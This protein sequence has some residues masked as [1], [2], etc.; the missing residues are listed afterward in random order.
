MGIRRWRSFIFTWTLLAVLV[1]PAAAQNVRGSIGGRVRDESGAVVPKATV[2]LMHQ[3]SSKT[4][5]TEAGPE[6]EFLFSNLPAGEYALEI[7]VTGF[8]KSKTSLTLLIGQKVEKDVTLKVGQATSVDYVE[9]YTEVVHHD[10]PSVGA[11]ISNRQITGLPL[12]GRNFATLSLLVPGVLPSAEGSALSVRGGFSFSVNGGREDSNVFQLDGVYNGDPTLNGA[13]VI[14]PVDAIR[15]FAVLTNSYDASFG[16]NSGGQINVALHRGGNAFHGTAYEFFRNAALDARN[17]FAPASEPDPKY[18]RNQFG[19]SAGGPIVRERTFFFA[20][21]EGRIA[22]E[23]IT[24]ISNVPTAAERSGDFTASF[25]PTPVVP[26]FGPLPIIPAFFQHPVG[27]AIAQLFPLPNRASPGAN[28]VSSPTQRDNEHHFD[29]RV[30]QVFKQA[31]LA[32]R[33]SF[34]DRDFFEPF[35]TAQGSSLVPGYGNHVTPRFHNLMVSETHT[36]SPNFVNEFRFGFNRVDSAVTHQNAGTSGNAA[37]GL[38]D[39]ASSRDLGLSQINITGFAT[40]GHEINSPNA[41]ANNTWQF[42]DQANWVRGKHA[43][44]F[45]FDF[46]KVSQNAFRDVQSR[47]FLSFLGVITGNPLA[48][49]LLGLPTVTGRALVD[50]PQRLRAESYQWFVSDA[51]RIHPSLLL[52]AGLRYEFVSPPVDPADRAQVYNP[53]TG[54]I[55]QVGTGGVP[56][57]G[58]A[59]DKNNFAPRLGLAWTL[60][61]SHGNTVLRAGYGMYY[62]QSP[63]APGEGL[64]FSPPFFTFNLAFQ[65][66]M[67]PPLTLSNPFPGAAFPIPTPPSALTYQRDLR[68]PYVQHWSLGVQQ[69]L[70]QGRVLEAVY[71]ASKGTKLL[72]GRDINQPA[73]S[74]V[75]PNLRPNP[76]FDDITAVESRASSTFGSLQLR[77]QQELRHG[78]TVLAGYTLSESDDDASSFFA[79]TGDPN[80]PQDSNNV[81]A[82]RARSN[83]DARH[84]FSLSYSYDLPGPQTH[85]W[86]RRFFG[87]W[88]SFGT[89]FLNTGRPFTVALLSTV[90]NSN[91]GRSVLGFGANDRP[92]IVGSPAVAQQSELAWFNTSA[93]AT[94]AFGSFGDAGRN[95]L[96]GPGFATFNFSLV[97]NIA[98][99]ERLNV[100]FRSEFF[101]LF[102]RTNYNLP[103]NFL[104]SPSFGR[105]T[106]AGDPRHVQFGVKFLW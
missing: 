61:K 27:T 101:N 50:N 86:A 73:P 8:Q 44:K 10:S 52:T 18:Q 99:S 46:R 37:V 19:V 30:D 21:Y 93:F 9:G 65:F 60:P 25:L 66:P 76:L 57:A 84:R 17:H 43:W 7:T 68:T 55:V 74:V 97:K 75:F 91:T 85:E 48:D 33:Y 45:G 47:G 83:F 70:G 62:D 90:D 34:G 58:Y 26:G 41:N 63:L 32:V 87:G 3:A 39:P 40:L 6:G 106:S 22:R 98:A 24:R 56:R 100:Q 94:P 53:A 14:P 80:F 92:N 38:P 59:S 36:L 5:E 15:E 16:R 104:G 35:S 54:G 12:D 20:D 2:R 79:S 103:D 96:E 82:E 71:A 29:V 72:S 13:G 89:L 42:V 69:R 64:Y 88:Q 28:F 11:Y 78:L 77:F 1:L 4:Q 102:N 31:D 67:L 49:V 23:G 95:I 105:I 81:R 51:W